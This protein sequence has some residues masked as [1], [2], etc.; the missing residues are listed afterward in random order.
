MQKQ[1]L[2]VY[3]KLGGQVCFENIYIVAECKIKTKEDKV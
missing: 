2:R 1:F 3:N